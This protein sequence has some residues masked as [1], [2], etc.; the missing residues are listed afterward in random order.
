MDCAC[1]KGNQNCPVQKHNLSPPEQLPRPPTLPAQVGAETRRRKARRKELEGGVS[2]DSNQLPEDPA[3]AKEL[4]G[5]ATAAS[6]TE[7]S[8]VPPVTVILSKL[9]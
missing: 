8:A 4:R 3:D 9:F 1:H 6:D 2:D 7:V 5:G